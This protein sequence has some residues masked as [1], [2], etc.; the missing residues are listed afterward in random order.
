MQLL[1]NNGASVP[2]VGIDGNTAL[3]MS[4]EHGDA[5]VTTLLTRLIHA[6]ADMEAYLYLLLKPLDYC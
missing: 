2:I 4:S 6:G 3:H 1:L 5:S